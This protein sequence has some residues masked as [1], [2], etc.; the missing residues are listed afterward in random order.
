MRRTP[1]TIEKASPSHEV[2]LVHLSDERPGI[3]DNHAGT[4]VATPIAEE[5]APQHGQFD[6]AVPVLTRIG[7][8]Q[9]AAAV[10]VNRA[11]SSD[12]GR[13]V[14][15]EGATA[16][17][18]GKSIRIGKYSAGCQ[19]IADNDDWHQFL[20]ICQAA[21]EIHG[22]SFSYTLIESNDIA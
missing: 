21:R 3:I 15:D 1:I 13:C 22:N 14:N 8:S 9:T 16:K 4:Y 10:D 7:A 18:G 5:G 19:V 2:G 6:T 20:D 17:A 11:T 12:F